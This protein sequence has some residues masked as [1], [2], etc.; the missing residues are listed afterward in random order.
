M[1][2][3]AVFGWVSIRSPRPWHIIGSAIVLMLLNVLLFS[4]ALNAS[5]PW[6]AAALSTQ[7]VATAIATTSI[8]R[9][10]LE[11]RAQAP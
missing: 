7:V 10:W 11:W 5:H 4:V 6:P 3:T 9:D 2:A 8:R 1:Y